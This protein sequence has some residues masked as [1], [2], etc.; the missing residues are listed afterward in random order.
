M[1]SGCDPSVGSK[2]NMFKSCGL[3]ALVS[4]APGLGFFSLGL[5][6]AFSSFC[7]PCLYLLLYLSRYCTVEPTYR[8]PNGILILILKKDKKGIK[9]SYNS[10]IPL[11]LIVLATGEASE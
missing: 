9:I 7:P 5:G 8:L 1:A 11:P 3:L 4:V 6:L 2:P 10:A